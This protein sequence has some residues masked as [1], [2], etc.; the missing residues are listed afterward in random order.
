MRGQSTGNCVGKTHFG[1]L[2]ERQW[3]GFVVLVRDPE[4]R[5]SGIQPL[6]WLASEQEAEVIVRQML[7]AK[8]VAPAKQVQ[9]KP[10]GRGRGSRTYAKAS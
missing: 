7:A 5:T 1:Y 8:A 4:A 3:S 9:A 6:A 2:I 10:R